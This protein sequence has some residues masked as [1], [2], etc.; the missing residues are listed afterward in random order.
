MRGEARR[1]MSVQKGSL[2]GRA[3]V[4]QSVKYLTLDFSSGHGLMVREF[5]PMSVQSLLW[6]LSLS[7]SLCPSSACALSLSQNK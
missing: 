1:E 5:N 4:A 6:I 2:L 3:Q 7:L